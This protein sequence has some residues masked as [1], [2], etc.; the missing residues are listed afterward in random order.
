LRFVDLESCFAQ[1]EPLARAKVRAVLMDTRTAQPRKV[2]TYRPRRVVLR[3]GRA[4]TLRAIQPGDASEI[5]QAFE[6]LSAESR[7]LRFMQHKKELDLKQVERGTNPVAGR[8][9]T[10]VATA[11]A[12]DGIDIVGATRYVEAKEPETCEFAVTVADDWNHQGLATILLR[13]L[14]RRAKRDGYRT[15]EGLVLA[16]NEPMLALARHLR[17]AAVPNT[18]DATVVVVRR[19]L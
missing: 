4:V 6:R 18:D 1:R 2:A 17:F 11:P 12:P 10:F 15:I 19:A 16:D 8:E 14:I 7:Y 3:D 13:S 5:V 9:F